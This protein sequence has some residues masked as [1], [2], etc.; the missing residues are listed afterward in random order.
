MGNVYLLSCREL[1][2]IDATLIQYVSIKDEATASGGLAEIQLETGGETSS[3]PPFIFV[4]F[5]GARSQGQLAEQLLIILHF[6]IL[7]RS[8]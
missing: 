7:K 3:L 1:D 5:F 8:S 6:S 2:E 4:R